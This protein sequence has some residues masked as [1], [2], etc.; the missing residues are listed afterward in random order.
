MMR[1]LFLFLLPAMIASSASAQ[2]SYK[3]AVLKYAGGGD[4]YSNPTSVP[5]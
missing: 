3:L 5:N 1:V 2:G 4:W